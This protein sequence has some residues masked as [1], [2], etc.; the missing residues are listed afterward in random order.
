MQ[1]NTGGLGQVPIPD[2]V[3]IFDDPEKLGAWSLSK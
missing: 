3:S 1:L 2:V